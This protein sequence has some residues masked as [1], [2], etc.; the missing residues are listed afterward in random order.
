MTKK[1]ALV[2]CVILIIPLVTGC[3]E[4]LMFW[5][6]KKAKEVEIANKK[7]PPFEKLFNR[8]I[9]LYNSKQYKDAIQA[10]LFLRENYPRKASYQSRITLYIADSHY[11]LKEYPEAIANYEEFIKLYPRNPDIPYAYFQIGMSNYDQRRTYDRDATFVRKAIES[12]EKVLQTAPPGVLVNESIRMIAFCQR[13]LAMHEFFI[14]DFYIR[15]HHYKSALLRYEDILQKFSQLKI[16]DR[17]HLGVAIAYLKMKKRN[18]AFRH[19]SYVVKKYPNT[20]YGKKAWKLLQKDFKVASVKELPDVTFPTKLPI[21]IAEDEKPAAILA[22][23]EK[24]EALKKVKASA[25]KKSAPKPTPKKPEKK[26]LAQKPHVYLPK[27][28]KVEKTPPVSP[29]KKA[30][31]KPPEPEPAPKAVKTP[32]P[33]PVPKPAVKITKTEEKKA[34]PKSQEMGKP[35]PVKV[36]TEVK[37]TTTKEIPKPPSKKQA[38]LEKTKEATVQKHS[39]EKEAP[40][41]S[42]HETRP[43]A[44][45]PVKK[46]IVKPLT[47][48]PAPKAVKTPAPSP[49][50][51]PPVKI[52]KAEE[53][54]VPPKPS[55]VEKPTPVKKA[56]SVKKPVAKEAPTLSKEPVKTAKKVEKKPVPKP[57]KT[58]PNVKKMVKTDRLPPKKKSTEKGSSLGP[59]G[60]IDTRLPIHISSDHVEA[61][62]GKNSVRFYGKVV[63]KQ[64][65]VTLKCDDLTA[66]YT[67]GGKA[68]DK[69]IAHGKVAINQR[70]KKVTCGKAIFYNAARKI[71]LENSPT[72]WD[73][74]NKLS[75]NKMILFLDKNEIQILGSRKKPTELVI[76]PEKE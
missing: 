21:V 4:S 71:V 30:A 16:Y 49:A 24:A 33:S 20:P 13:E 14:A 42:K 61:K 75:G 19:L 40:A 43:P 59:V 44:M 57:E 1:I 55:A 68:I 38:P 66:Y 73:G 60:T 54:E 9:E 51:K 62:Q 10:L 11:Q 12:F 67:P 76:Y 74:D 34:P 15:T 70:N 7:L 31:I 6:K 65:D 18:K 72:A 28:S 47:P 64:R 25:E 41:P 45:P 63:V 17:A 36:T 29:V 48:E 39:P 8:T 2:L 58:P 22:Q 32:A 26:E 52:A 23:A 53:K 35:A 56:T 37:K 27:I 5:R 46:A 3:G 50:L 69:I